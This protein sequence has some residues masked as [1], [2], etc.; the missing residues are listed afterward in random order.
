MNVFVIFVKMRLPKTIKTLYAVMFVR[1]I[2]AK[3]VK[4]IL[5]QLIQGV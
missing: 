5:K 2:Y 4:M 1:M 3:N